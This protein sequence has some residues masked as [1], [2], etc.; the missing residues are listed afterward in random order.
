MK[1]KHVE[2]LTRGKKSGARIGSRSVPHRL[3]Q[4][5]Q[6]K[7]SIA[8]RR[9]YLTLGFDARENLENIWRKYCEVKRWPILILRKY[10][11]GG[12]PP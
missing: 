1:E 10:Q 2:N 3:R 6:T 8:I 11:D 5:E 9:K 4:H 7:L 12:L